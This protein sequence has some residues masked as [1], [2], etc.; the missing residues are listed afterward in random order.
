MA[1][2]I[3]FSTLL[4]AQQLPNF[5]QYRS[6]SSLNNPAAISSNYMA[7]EQNGSIGTSYRV[8]WSDV[9]AAP[10]TFV[11]QGDYLMDNGGGTSLLFGGH[12]INDQTGPLATTGVYGKIGGVISRKPESGGF[13]VGLT[14]GAVQFG[15]KSKELRLRDLDDLTAQQNLNSVYADV[16]VGIFAYQRM[17]GKKTKGDFLYGGVS[18]PQ[19]IGSTVSIVDD[20]GKEFSLK[21][22]QHIYG[23]IGY[24]HYFWNDSFIEPSV[25]VKYVPNA[26]INVDANIRYF[27]DES[28]LWIGAGGSSSKAA[29]IEFGVMLGDNTAYENNLQIGYGYDYSFNSFGPSVGGTHEVNVA[30]V[31][32]R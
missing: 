28:L 12:V 32:G 6:Y 15:V 11:L 8:Q 22:N 30:Y 31:F 1:L 14:A 4:H 3:T 29:H 2:A 10:R 5:T 23:N 24:L 26:P 18:I 27:F 7:F 19:I 16:G 17:G 21:R 20:E 9:I 25:W 13:C